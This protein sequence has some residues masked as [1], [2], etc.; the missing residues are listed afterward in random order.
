MNNEP[1][2]ASI[3]GTISKGRVRLETEL[4]SPTE[5]VTFDST[6]LTLVTLDPL[7]L[8]AQMG[9]KALRAEHIDGGG[10][11]S[12]QGPWFRVRE[13][14]RYRV[15]IPEIPG[16]EP[17]APVEVNIVEGETREVVVQLVRLQ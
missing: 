14:G 3:E 10:S 2:S 13:P 11:M 9:R 7:L 1:V 16:Y 4:R 6:I 15:P 17:H 12:A 8:L 5:P